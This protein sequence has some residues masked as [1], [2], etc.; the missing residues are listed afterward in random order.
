MANCGCKPCSKEMPASKTKCKQFSLCVGNKSLHYDGNCL[1][2]T[3][4]K[5][6]IPDGTYTSITFKNGCI[7]GVDKAP[8]PIIPHKLVVTVQHRLQ[9]YVV[10]H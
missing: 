8:L 1:F 3:D 4:R 2:V 5:Y 6:K 7:T 10:N 9:K